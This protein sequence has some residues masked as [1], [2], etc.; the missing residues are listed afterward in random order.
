M[1]EVVF[2]Y[3]GT[4]PKMGG[5]LFGI[6][7][8]FHLL[9][10][11]DL[12][13]TVSLNGEDA[14]RNEGLEVHTLRLDESTVALKS[15]LNYATVK[16]L[17]NRL[18]RSIDECQLPSTAVL[19]PVIND[20]NTRDLTNEKHRVYDAVFSPLDIG[21]STALLTSR[22]EAERFSTEFPASGYIIKPNRGIRG[23]E[24]IKLSGS[25]LSHLGET[26]FDGSKIIQPAYDFTGALPSYLQPYDL[27]STEL[28]NDVA[29]SDASKELRIYGFHDPNQTK[30]FAVGRAIKDG[31]DYWFFVD[32]DTLPAEVYEK[33]RAA[34]KTTAK[35]T[36]TIAMF[37]ALDYGY[38]RV[39][40][41]DPGWH[42][43]ELN[44]KQPYMIGYDKHEGIAHKLRA[45]FADQIYNTAQNSELLSR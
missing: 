45:L 18:N 26:T 25:R 22:D 32:P 15:L 21:I 40:D 12:K 44:S 31:E 42:V 14:F 20:N 8:I 38:G 9:Q 3:K 13:P 30:L 24:V 17:I 6:P 36:G 11:R 35:V 1:S 28:F 27:A 37:G 29:A 33:S 23:N 7:Q 2:A 19:P 4:K 5:N 39:C 16:V 34:F 43:I 10:Q 41:E